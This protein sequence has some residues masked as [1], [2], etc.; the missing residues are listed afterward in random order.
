MGCLNWTVV[1]CFL[2]SRCDIVGKR[3]STITLPDPD[4]AVSPRGSVSYPAAQGDVA[5]TIYLAVNNDNSRFVTVIKPKDPQSKIAQRLWKTETAETAEAD[6]PFRQVSCTEWGIYP[7]FTP[8]GSKVAFYDG[9]AIRILDTISGDTERI[10]EPPR[11]EGPFEASSPIK[12]FAVS[13]GGHRVAVATLHDLGRRDSMFDVIKLKNSD[14]K[15]QLCYSRDGNCLFFIYIGRGILKIKWRDI[16]TR[17][18]FKTK[19][20]QSVVSYEPPSYIICHNGQYQMLLDVEFAIKSPGL[21]SVLRGNRNIE[22]KRILLSL[23]EGQED[24]APSP[25]R[26]ED[27]IILSHGIFLRVDSE[28]RI[29]ETHN[30]QG[31]GEF[32]RAGTKDRIVAIRR[33][34]KDSGTVMFMSNQGKFY[35]KEFGLHGQMEWAQRSGS[36]ADSE[37]ISISPVS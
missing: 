14:R 36:P 22:R 28:G 35:S 2:L 27:D 37:H 9:Y 15:P 30:S 12:A 18:E 21:S 5:S 1:Q 7:N 19:L 10:I 25:G 3:I 8:D 13:P 6:E 31:Y 26:G 17:K 32:T 34:S 4:P 11:P 29:E 33:K 16:V 23:L 20:N 24:V